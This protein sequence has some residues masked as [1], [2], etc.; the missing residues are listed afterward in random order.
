MRHVDRYLAALAGGPLTTPQLAAR[1]GVHA[2][3]V[4][5]SMGQL[6]RAGYV[7]RTREGWQFVKPPPDPVPAFPPPEPRAVVPARVQWIFLDILRAAGRPLTA[8][9][10]DAAWL[11]R[12]LPVCCPTYALVQLRK[13]CEVGL[14]DRARGSRGVYYYRARREPDPPPPQEVANV[15]AIGEIL[16]AA[17]MAA[18]DSLQQA[19]RRA[20]DIS[21]SSWAQY[22]SGVYGRYLERINQALAC[23][24]LRVVLAVAT[25]DD[26]VPAE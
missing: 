2:T 20:G 1:L 18:G 3:S 12:G 19:A 16:R 22:E 17:R 21:S 23:Y 8:R 15:A 6:R 7:V 24:G 11:A 13:M 9:E 5:T 10:V 25:C 14:V 4:S 26:G